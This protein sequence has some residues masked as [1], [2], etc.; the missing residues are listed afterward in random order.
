MCKCFNKDLFSDFNTMM[1][2][3]CFPMTLSSYVEEEKHFVIWAK[4]SKSQS[5]RCYLW[6]V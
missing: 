6:P 5:L 3:L 1:N 2:V 4:N